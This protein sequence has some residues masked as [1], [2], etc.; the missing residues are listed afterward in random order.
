MLE[1]LYAPLF[2]SVGACFV[3]EARNPHLT[4]WPVLTAKYFARAL[5]IEFSQDGT[6]THSSVGLPAVVRRSFRDS[7]A[8]ISGLIVVPFSRQDHFE[9][10]VRPPRDEH[11]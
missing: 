10:V 11:D 7:I 6:L 4:N 2:Q 5:G 9:R 3:Y 8:L 1:A